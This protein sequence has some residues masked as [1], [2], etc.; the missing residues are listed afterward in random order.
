MHGLDAME[1]Y[2]PI[3]PPN[4]QEWL[5]LDEATRLAL[6]EDYHRRARIALPNAHVHAVVHAV[7]EAQAALGDETPVRRTLDRL[8]SEGLD[9][10]EA[11]HAVARVFTDFF[12]DV[13]TGAG[14]ANATAID[15]NPE[16]FAAVERMTVEG[17]RRVADE[18]AGPEMEE[19]QILRG[20]AGRDGV[21]FDAIHAARA[22][23]AVMGPVFLHVIERYLDG[24]PEPHDEDALFLIF[25]LLGEWREKSAYRLLARL[26]RRS[27]EE[28]DAILGDAT[29]ETSHRVI[30]AVFDGDPQPLYDIIIDEQA[31]EFVRSSMCNALAIIARQNLLCRAEACRFL[32]AW[33]H[34]TLRDEAPT[35]RGRSQRGNRAPTRDTRWPWQRACHV[36]RHNC[37]AVGMVCLQS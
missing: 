29:T 33:L 18:S 6:V 1:R 9:R 37:R 8:M 7:V 20:L 14:G 34:R 22:Q 2:D 35:L 4:P 12:F 32:Q 13:M 26:L 36:R 21:A 15:P 17:W 19:A 27:G 5:A 16:Y 23:R 28:L 25:H 24:K 3:S 30:A 10:H 11:I 31:D